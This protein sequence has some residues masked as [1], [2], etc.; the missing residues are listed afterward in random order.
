MWKSLGSLAILF[1]GFHS[2]VFADSHFLND[3]LRACG[4]PDVRF[5][6]QVR[7]AGRAWHQAVDKI[8]ARY[9][10]GRWVL[11][12]KKDDQ[13]L[14]SIASVLM[15]VVQFDA[16]GKGVVVT[17]RP[18]S[19][20]DRRF[21]SGFPDD[22]REKF[23]YFLNHE[24]I[25]AIPQDFPYSMIIQVRAIEEEQRVQFAQTQGRFYPPSAPRD[26][27]RMARIDLSGK[28]KP[29]RL[30]R[31]GED[32]LVVEVSLLDENTSARVIK[33]FIREPLML[34]RAREDIPVREENTS[35]A[36]RNYSTTFD[37]HNDLLIRH[38]ASG[39]GDSSTP[40][41]FMQLQYYPQKIDASAQVEK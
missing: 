28:S 21:L 4:K 29:L 9:G 13:I 5:E 1:I 35:R 30:P 7:R 32:S 12:D 33:E 34:R 18:I 24:L 3:L 27:S 8:K 17:S 15:G 14:K 40:V 38:M 41:I 31:Y 20:Q 26:E 6:Y 11:A 10:L 19:T 23:F 2:E 25:S 16:Q 36:A 37:G 22:S 39:D